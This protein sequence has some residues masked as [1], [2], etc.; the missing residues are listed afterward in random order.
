MA[1][2]G[3]F[4][5]A[6]GCAPDRTTEDYQRQKLQEDLAEYEQVVG[7][8]SGSI[9]FSE[10]KAGDLTLV[11]EAR[12]QVARNATGV[13]EQQP[14][15]FGRLIFQGEQSYSSRSVVFDFTDAFFDENGGTFQVNIPINAQSTGLGAGGEKPQDSG[16]KSG[17]GQT[18]KLDLTASLSGELLSGTLSAT[19]F[20]DYGARFELKREKNLEVEI[21]S[22]RGI[23]QE[24][25][26]KY[27][28]KTT[29]HG[30]T[31]RNAELVLLRPKV[32]PEESFFELFYPVHDLS[33]SLNY[34]D[35]VQLNFLNSSWDKRI[36]LLKGYSSQLSQSCSIEDL[37]LECQEIDSG[38]T[39]QHI[40]SEL[41]VVGVSEFREVPSDNVFRPGVSEEDQ[42]KVRAFIGTFPF[43]YGGERKGKLSLFEKNQSLTACSVFRSEKT[44]QATLDFGSNVTLLFAN[45]KWDTRDGILKG[46]TQ[47][48][49]GSE[50]TDLLLNC[51][52]GAGKSPKCQLISSELGFLTNE[53]ATL[54]ELSNPDQ[55]LPDAGHDAEVQSQ[56]YCGIVLVGGTKKSASTVRL[57]FPRGRSKN[58]FTNWIYPEM[59][60]RATVTVSS[61]LSR[62]RDRDVLW[63][64]SNALY[65]QELKSVS[66]SSI[67]GANHMDL[68]C[69]ASTQDGINGLSCR[70]LSNG[71]ETLKGFYCPEGVSGPSCVC[72]GDGG[73]R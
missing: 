34:G 32:S 20:S 28:G 50:K 63:N 44:I 61:S 53:S 8:F 18:Q 64:Y 24:V 59:N 47:L 19:G 7:T 29:F 68:E 2:F 51:S 31:T 33:V 6:V 5:L 14:V 42:T 11:V 40:T 15:L 73:P 30:E 39:C 13:S 58:E 55:G 67:L 12:T 70:Q 72:T 41:G 43:R 65:D 69:E 54:G 49:R 45:S 38:F 52:L 56:F 36:G 26:R 46:E 9:M 60:A 71:A 25:V 22:L 48:Q 27:I 23:S 37:L 3:L 62:P 57:V 1:V 10:K 4:V 17:F 21:P 35:F 16:S 66:A